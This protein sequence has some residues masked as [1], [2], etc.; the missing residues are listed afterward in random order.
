M[1]R[2]CE[3]YWRSHQ[4]P[5]S[6]MAKP[7]H[8]QSPRN[9]DEELQAGRAVRQDGPAHSRSWPNCRRR[10]EKRMSANP[11]TNGGLLLK[12]LKIA[13]LPGLRRGR[14]QPGRQ[15]RGVDAGHGQVPPRRDEGE[16]GQQ[17]LPPGQPGRVQLQP[18]AG[19]A[20]SHQPRL[21]RRD[22][23]VRRPPEPGRPR[24]GDP[25]RAPVP[26]LAGGLPADRPARLLLVLRGVH[27][28]HRF[29]VQPAR[30]VAE[31]DAA[32]SLAAADRVAELPAVLAG[33]AA[34][35]QRF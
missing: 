31:G 13:R 19:R 11:H 17:E 32:H 7:G 1:A 22:V 20:R 15:G 28:H 16:P 2:R 35:P 8:V 14:A 5:L 9:L 34:G 24:H 21:G 23:A 18:L 26:G 27:P 4:V 33:L 3:G 30:Q 6:D 10:G 29:D 25:Q 12:D